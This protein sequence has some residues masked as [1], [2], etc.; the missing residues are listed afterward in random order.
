VKKSASYLNID[1]YDVVISIQEAVADP[2]ATAEA[3]KPLVEALPETAQARAITLKIE[4]QQKIMRDENDKAAAKRLAHPGADVSAEEARWNQAKANVGVEEQ[5]LRAVLE[6]VEAAMPRLYAEAAV[7]FPPGPGEKHLGPAEETLLTEK[8]AELRQEQQEQKH[9]VLTLAG[10][11]IPDWRGAEYYLKTAG[12]WAKV[13][14]EHIGEPL[15]EGSVLS[16]SL[17]PEQRAEIAGQ[18]EAERIAALS[19][20]EKEAERQAR[21][22]A[23]ADEADRLDRRARIQGSDF[24]AA[25]WYRENKV[26]VEA[27]YA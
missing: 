24:D 11:V 8:W 1:G 4:A 21:L 10:E 13:K 9:R 7:Y 3:V 18:A 22:D 15:P 25:A 19:P 20:E 27:K 23:L 5:N 12:T 6:T 2:A 14:V 17:T 26:P 16:D